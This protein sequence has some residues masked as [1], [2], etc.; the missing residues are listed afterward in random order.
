MP[1]GGIPE[2]LGPAILT[3]ALARAG[4]LLF[5]RPCQLCGHRVEEPG[6]GTACAAC[7]DGL[8]AR[9]WPSLRF[10]GLRAP[11][12]DAVEAAWAYGGSLRELIHAWKFGGHPSLRRPFGAALAR[13]CEPARD[14][15]CDAVVPVPLGLQSWDE[16]GFDAAGA[17]AASVARAWR[18]PLRPALFWARQRQRQSGLN[19][20]ERRGNAAGAFGSRPVEGLRLLLVDDLLS[21]G[22][23]A[24]DAARALKAAG[25]AF[26]GVAALAHAEWERHGA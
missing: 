19:A 24:Q 12:F 9:P 5:Q 13:R 23:T 21:S 11:A 22:A 2:P 1:C 20:V 4:G 15:G 6:L 8:E 7:W 10:P 25:A 14:W 16:R 3:R 26:V 18:L 17:L